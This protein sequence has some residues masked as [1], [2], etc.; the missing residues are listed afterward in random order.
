AGMVRS[1]YYPESRAGKRLI[2]QVPEAGIN[3]AQLS[4]MRQAVGSMG[5]DGNLMIGTAGANAENAEFARPGDVSKILDKLGVQVRSEAV[6]T[7][8]PKALLERRPEIAEAYKNA[9]TV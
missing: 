3:E 6:P 8:A 7:V 9:G 4:A 1:R 5:R 2:F